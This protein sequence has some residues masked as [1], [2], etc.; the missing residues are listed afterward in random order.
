MPPRRNIALVIAGGASLGSYEAGVMT[1]LLYALEYLNRTRKPDEPEYVID[2]MTG[3][4]AG[5]LTA[6]LVARIMMYDIEARSRLYK[7]WVERI[8]IVELMQRAPD[9]AL[10]SKAVI[11]SL[12]REFI[13]E[14]SEDAASRTAVAS[15]APSTLRLSLSLSNMNGID[16][17]LP[18]LST[19]MVT[20]KR[21]VTTLFSDT[22]EFRL[23]EQTLLDA[24]LWTEIVDAAIASSSFPIAFQPEAV[25]R[26]PT[27]YPESLLSQP[28]L[29]FFPSL[30]QPGP[31]QRPMTF[32]DGGIFNNEPLQEAIKLA[33]D[34]DGGIP[35]PNRLFLL[36]DP[37]INVSSFDP[38]VDPEAPLENHVSRLIQMI[39]NQGQAIQWLRQAYLKNTEIAWRDELVKGIT[40]LVRT[41]DIASDAQFVDG[42]QQLT[43][44]VIREKSRLAEED[45]IQPA[46]EALL[47]TV[48]DRFSKEYASLKS[49]PRGAQK[50]DVFRNLVFILNTVAN[51]EDK[52]TLQFSVIGSTPGQTAGDQI[53]GFGGFFNQEWRQYDYRQGRIEAHNRLREILAVNYPKEQANGRTI[54]D[55]RIEQDFSDVTL[56]D[57]DRDLRKAIRRTILDRFAKL[58]GNTLKVPASGWLVTQVLLRPRVSELLKL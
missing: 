32:L 51:L 24:A 25:V 52:A 20:G 53:S 42:L 22:A 37:A 47:K 11:Q 38:A 17:A 1:E 13:I 12:A 46:L 31:S 29:K 57:A 34:A 21:F 35:D 14:G 58:V 55:Y 28:P 48:E 16:Y 43:Q 33:R 27:D 56:S 8:D 10:L 40:Y 39:F 6:I 36:V 49:V 44:R 7:S 41:S 5:A 50:Q 23:S 45:D 54:D 30:N 18:A 15:F 2:V 19:A 9:N 26:R 4:S 3:G